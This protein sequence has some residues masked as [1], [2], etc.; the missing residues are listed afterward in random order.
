VTFTVTQREGA[1]T[2]HSTW[3]KGWSQNGA[4]IKTKPDVLFAQGAAQQAAKQIFCRC[5]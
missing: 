5:P 4:C 1:A 3:V 2:T